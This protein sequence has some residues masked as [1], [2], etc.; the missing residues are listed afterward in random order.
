MISGGTVL[1]SI[2]PSVAEPPSN[3]LNP[4]V[5]LLPLLLASC[6]VKGTVEIVNLRHKK[7]RESFP[8]FT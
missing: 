3:L 8:S 6:H 1:N 5:S 7:F 4:S 2:A